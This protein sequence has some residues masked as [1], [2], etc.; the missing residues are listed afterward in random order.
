MTLDNKEEIQTTYFDEALKLL[1]DNKPLE[2]PFT[3]MLNDLEV[4]KLKELWYKIKEVD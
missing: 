4:S 2:Q 3:L 1:R